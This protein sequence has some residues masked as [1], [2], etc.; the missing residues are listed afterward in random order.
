MHVDPVPVGTTPQ[1]PSSGIP[2]M[3]D[4][5]LGSTSEVGEAP[6]GAAFEETDP[7]ARAVEQD[8]TVAGLGGGGEPDDGLVPD[9]A[10]PDP[11]RS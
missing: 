8:T 7:V 6:E 10:E 4:P 2:P 3:A 5:A 9:F 11:D 1:D